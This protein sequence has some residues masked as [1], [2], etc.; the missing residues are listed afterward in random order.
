[1]Q[2]VIPPPTVSF[3]NLLSL[4]LLV[5]LLQVML[6][7][8]SA[9]G[10]T[11]LLVRFK[12]GAFLGGNFIATVGIDF[13]VRVITFNSPEWLLMLF[14]IPVP[15]KGLSF[16]S[17]SHIWN[18]RSNLMMSTKQQEIHL[19]EWHQANYHIISTENTSS[20]R[21]NSTECTNP[22]T[23]QSGSQT[24]CAARRCGWLHKCLGRCLPTS[25]SP[26]KIGCSSALSWRSH[27]ADRQASHIYMHTH[28]DCCWIWSK[29]LQYIFLCWREHKKIGC[30]DQ[31]VFM[32]PS[33]QPPICLEWRQNTHTNGKSSR[34]VWKRKLRCISESDALFSLDGGVVDI[35]EH[36]GCLTDRA[37][38]TSSIQRHGH[39]ILSL[40]KQKQQVL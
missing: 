15:I 11:C 33:P 35:R 6:L 25:L 8:D 40:F 7:G 31:V 2:I 26:G 20:R 30:L 24:T 4:S 37:A 34:E 39:L 12:D 21:D 13:R 3:C 32:P 36:N 22:L 10:K 5:G 29:Y 38:W 16:V 23:N 28:G 14:I 1:M 19:L 17:F 9:V 27:T 18:L